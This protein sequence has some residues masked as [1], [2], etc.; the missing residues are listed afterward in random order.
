MVGKLHTIFSFGIEWGQC[1]NCIACSQ[2]CCAN[3]WQKLMLCVLLKLGKEEICTHMMCVHSWMNERVWWL[4]I[5]SDSSSV[6]PT[7]INDLHQRTNIAKI[8]KFASFCATWTGTGCT[9]STCTSCTTFTI[10]KI[11]PILSCIFPSA[12]VGT[13]GTRTASTFP[14]AH[15]RDRARLHASPDAHLRER[16][17]TVWLLAWRHHPNTNSQVRAR[18]LRQLDGCWICY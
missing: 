6:H 2:T 4:C 5:D 1:P 7:S 9:G 11:Y 18:M 14:A 15:L 12:T 3:E 10:R 16:R 17:M 13:G 8:Q